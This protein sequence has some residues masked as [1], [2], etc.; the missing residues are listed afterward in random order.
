MKTLLTAFLL[1]ALPSAALAQRHYAVLSLVGDE[2]MIVQ[3]EMMTGSRLDT[4]SRQSGGLRHLPIIAS[5]PASLKEGFGSP[6]GV[7]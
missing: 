2:M 5:T 6:F 3:R 4:N 7:G 1:L